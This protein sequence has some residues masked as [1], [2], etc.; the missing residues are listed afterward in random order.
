[1]KLLNSNVF[2]LWV[3]FRKSGEDFRFPILSV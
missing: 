2:N 1:M 3:V